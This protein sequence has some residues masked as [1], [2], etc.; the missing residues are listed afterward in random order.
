MSLLEVSPVHS[1]TESG[2]PYLEIVPSH[3]GVRVQR[4]EVGHCLNRFWTIWLR[5]LVLHDTARKH[6]FA[7]EL[8]DS[9][10][11][12][13]SNTTPEG[14]METVRALAARIV[15]LPNPPIVRQEWSAKTNGMSWIVRGDVDLTECLKSLRLPRGARVE[16]GYWSVTLW[17]SPKCLFKTRDLAL[18]V[19]YHVATH[20]Q[21]LN[22]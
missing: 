8:R 18:M 17:R 6:G 20:L 16:G 22:A 5:E 9:S 7:V 12:V 3:K 11:R 4:T 2:I 21:S 1:T 14:L 13:S 10:V 15:P 19:E